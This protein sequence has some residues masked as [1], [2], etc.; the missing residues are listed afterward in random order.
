VDDGSTDGT[1][2]LITGSNFKNTVLVS[3]PDDGI[4]DAINKGIGLARG[5][6]ID[7][8]H[9]DDYYSSV[10]ILAEVALKF[11]NPELDAVYADA[12][13]SQ[14]DNPSKI[15]KRYRSNIFRPQLIAWGWMPSHTTIFLRK[16][17]F[18]QYGTYKIDY[19]IAA[20]YEFVARIYSSGNVKSN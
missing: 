11:L 20:D 6:I 15:V 3:E 18:Q 9:S 8:L 5:E 4:Y 10:E 7:L 14:A 17:V 19:K 13:F 12:T 16:K 2:E 1:L